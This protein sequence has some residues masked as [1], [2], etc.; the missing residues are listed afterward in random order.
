MAE[1]TKENPSLKILE[2]LEQHASELLE[3]Y[4]DLSRENA[5]LRHQLQQMQQERHT[6][7][8]K[9]EMA[10]SRIEAMI[11]RLKTME[12]DS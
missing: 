5:Q 7:I 8:E 4:R 9:H 3:R 12:E 6:L 2:S 11:Q 1:P 10:K